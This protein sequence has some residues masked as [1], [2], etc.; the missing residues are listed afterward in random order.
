L[1]GLACFGSASAT[2]SASTYVRTKLPL[3]GDRPGPSW[4]SEESGIASTRKP[5]TRG[6]SVRSTTSCTSC[7]GL[8]PETRTELSHCVR[9]VAPPV[10]RADT[11]VDTI[12]PFS[13]R[14]TRSHSACFAS[15]LGTS[16]ATLASASARA[17]F[18]DASFSSSAVDAIVITGGTLPRFA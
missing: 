12:Q 8:A 9:I 13:Y 6:R 17:F 1:I 5:V 4:G 18:S 11:G 7:A 2:A 14:A 15:A 16:A 3:S 10:D